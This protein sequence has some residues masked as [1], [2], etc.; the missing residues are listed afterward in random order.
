MSKI[1]PMAWK[2]CVELLGEDRTFEWSVD[3]KRLTVTDVGDKEAKAI[4]AAVVAATRVPAPAQTMQGTEDRTVRPAPKTE[5][6]EVPPAPEPEQTVQ[7]PPDLPISESM[8]SMEAM[9]KH[10]AKDADKIPPENVAQIA[11]VVDV[12]RAKAEE[13]Q[14]S[15]APSE[16]PVDADAEVQRMENGASPDGDLPDDVRNSVSVRKL[17]AHFAEQGI[18]DHAELTEVVLRH[19]DQAKSLK[20][21]SPERRRSAVEAAL[22]GLA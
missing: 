2:Y 10:A 11:E 14:V 20:R 22:I 16:V 15:S 12:F 19:A 21:K 1:E 3:S 5:A 7:A 18:S 4:L 9:I 17:V 8:A 6:V 13:L